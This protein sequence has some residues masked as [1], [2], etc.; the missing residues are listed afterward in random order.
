MS[1]RD[2]RRFKKWYDQFIL[3]SDLKSP[4]FY[5]AN[6]LYAIDYMVRNFY[7]PAMKNIEKFAYGEEYE[8][9]ESAIRF[10]YF[11]GLCRAAEERER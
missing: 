4:V 6:F 7:I 11:C 8:V 5:E 1:F 9:F 3:D 2:K 10:G